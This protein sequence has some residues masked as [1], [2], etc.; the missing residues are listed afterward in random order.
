MSRVADKISIGISLTLDKT[1]TV[2][3]GRATQYIDELYI[4]SLQD[5]GGLVRLIPTGSLD[6]ELLDD[7][8]GLV[9][10]GGGDFPP[11]KKYPLEEFV[12]A[13]P[14]QRSADAELLKKARKRKLPVLGICYGMQLMATERSGTLFDHIPADLPEAG[15]HKLNGNKLHDIFIESD[16]VLARWLG[17]HG[18]AQVNS[19]HHQA[20]RDPGRGFR[21]IARALDGVVEAIEA[22]GPWTAIGVQWHPEEMPEPHRKK[23]FSGFLAAC[24]RLN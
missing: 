13:P 9:F 8:D 1:G 15:N 16:S 6:E 2:R 7:L 19:R 10:P 3:E 5:V 11:S 24:G 23:L 21:I 12:L 17:T 20:V 4:R 22:E 18:H 14:E